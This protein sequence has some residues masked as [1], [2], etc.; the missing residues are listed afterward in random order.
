MENLDAEKILANFEDLTGNLKDIKDFNILITNILKKKNAKNKTE[1]LI[2]FLD[3]LNTLKPKLKATK[4]LE[5]SVY[6]I[7]LTEK[8]E[9]KFIK[10]FIAKLEERS[11]TDNSCTNLLNSLFESKDK[12]KT[13]GN[14]IA[15]RLRSEG[16]FFQEYFKTCSDCEGLLQALFTSNFKEENLIHYFIEFWNS[17][18][19]ISEDSNENK[20]NKKNQIDGINQKET[21]AKQ[22]VSKSGAYNVFLDSN[23]FKSLFLSSF[24]K[25]IL[26]RTYSIEF[27]EEMK[28]KKMPKEIES[29]L[30]EVCY[31]NRVKIDSF[32]A[33]FDFHNN[34]HKT[35]PMTLKSFKNFLIEL[36]DNKKDKSHLIENF[37]E[38]LDFMSKHYNQEMFVGTIFEELLSNNFENNEISQI[39]NDNKLL[40]N[41][42]KCYNNHIENFYSKLAEFYSDNAYILN[43]KCPKLFNLLLAN[44]SEQ[45]AFTKQL[46]IFKTVTKLKHKRIISLFEEIVACN[47]ENIAVNLLRYLLNEKGLED[48]AMLLESGKLSE[49]VL[50]YFLIESIL[51]RA[52]PIMDIIN[53]SLEAFL[54]GLIEEIFKQ[55]EFP[56]QKNI[57]LT[58]FLNCSSKITTS[59]LENIISFKEQ[60]KVAHRKK[61]RYIYS[62]YLAY[63]IDFYFLLDFFPKNDFENLSLIINRLIRSEKYHEALKILL[64]NQFNDRIYIEKEHEHELIDFLFNQ[65]ER[66]KP[67]KR[68]LCFSNKEQ[69]INF[70]D[71]NDLNHDADYDE[72]YDEF[73]DDEENLDYADNEASDREA[74]EVDDSDRIQASKA[75]RLKEKTA[76]KQ[77]SNKILDYIMFFEYNKG[78]RLDKSKYLNA[79][80]VVGYLPIPNRTD[81]FAPVSS[82]ALLI[83]I[84]RENIF[85]IDSIN[86]LKN[87]QSLSKRK[88]AIDFEYADEAISIMQISDGKYVYI[89][90]YMRLIQCS[91]FF[92]V[93]NASFKN[94][95]FLAFDM[96]SSDLNLL[97][98]TF[99]EFF[100]KAEVLDLKKIYEE[101]LKGKS[102]SLA[103]MALM[104]LGKPLCKFFQ[105]SKWDKRPLLE[106]QVHYSSMDSHILF[107][108]H[109]ALEN[110]IKK[111][112]GDNLNSDLYEN[113][114]IKEKK[115]L[116][117]KK[118]I[119]N[120]AQEQMNFLHAER[121]MIEE[122]NKSLMDNSLNVNK[123]FFDFLTI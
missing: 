23:Q 32:L 40:T 67:K 65:H 58:S 13:F 104:L 49:D 11:K 120:F 35:V 74:A 106:G 121:Q 21:A 47:Y 22:D 102:P 123:L 3:N 66:L 105:C 10:N 12:F 70:C 34:I 5:K 109:E 80:R 113:I 28:K 111:G 6:S 54:N 56:K 60:F 7:I 90:D 82:D 88:L 119:K 63:E 118:M 39:K 15:Q 117:A 41:L 77:R 37:L 84:P 81:R 33:E 25:A 44:L 50:N 95:V 83:D 36:F 16:Q 14:L 57:A 1:I 38:N 100:I 30:S 46:F 98:K 101:N 4:K 115:D 108:L 103:N 43:M 86:D 27:I 112:K 59:N 31:S 89:I 72:T 99:R 97:N 9:E 96:G 79:L 19:S 51:H 71:S 75:K 87:L 53:T 94:C 29:I 92:G 20:N 42:N 18:D 45:N 2:Q 114:S 110:L 24:K 62:R 69:E 85:F 78:C 61:I 68:K 93:F 116:K 26:N 55:K 73:L 107:K 64:D 8:G 76:S 48:L 122:A 52:A 17:L 91:E